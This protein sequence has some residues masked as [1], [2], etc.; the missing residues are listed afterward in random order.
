MNINSCYLL[1]KT[2]Q[3]LG[4]IK[5]TR[6]SKKMRLKKPKT[7]K[8]GKNKKIKLIKDAKKVVF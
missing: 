7:I 6:L 5:P 8:Q 3:K 1:E 2:K 4:R